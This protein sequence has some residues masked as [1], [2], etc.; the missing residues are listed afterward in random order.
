MTTLVEKAA[1][2]FNRVMQAH[3]INLKSVPSHFTPGRQCILIGCNE[4]SH[5][6]AK[7]IF[8]ELFKPAPSGI[9]F[10]Y[11]TYDS[12]LAT[13]GVED[14]ARIKPA[15]LRFYSTNKNTSKGEYC[16]MCIELGLDKDWREDV[17]GIAGHQTEWMDELYYRSFA[18]S[19][20]IESDRFWR[21]FAANGTGVRL[22]IEITTSPSYPDLRFIT[23]EGSH[24][25][26]ALVDVRETFQREG[27]NLRIEGF[28]RMPAFGQLAKYSWQQE[29]RLIAKRFGPDDSSFP[30][31]VS[32]NSQHSCNYIDCS[33]TPPDSERFNLRLV[34][35]SPGPNTDE[36]R[37][38]QIAELFDQH[39]QNHAAMPLTTSS[40]S[41]QS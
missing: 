17:S 12:F 19:P 31:K 32:W 4:G 28:P 16:P 10:L 35:V 24:A 37:K 21:E 2:I 40:T 36:A 14:S 41:S 9:Y 30:W 1:S 18:A 6:F 22:A 3:S 20:E 23:Y 38:L 13:M 8:N 15:E 26:T 11:M 34:G 5:E 39:L 29:V 33:L 25:V 7:S 27:Y